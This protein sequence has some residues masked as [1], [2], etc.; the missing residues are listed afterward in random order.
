MARRWC[1]TIAVIGL[2]ARGAQAQELRGVV[3]DSATS[4]PIPA[5]VLMLLDASG[6]TLGRNI[7]NERGEFRI[8][9]SP[10]IARLRVVRIGFRPRELPVPTTASIDIL[11][12]SLPTMLEPV[13]VSAGATCPRR[14]DDARTYALLEQARAGLLSVVVARDA[15]PGALVLL[16]FERTIE[17][18][19]DRIASQRVRIDSTVRAKT[20]FSAAH[21]ATDFVQRGF[22]G[23]SANQIIF[24]APDA[25]VLLDDGFAAGYCFRI[26]N[27][28][29]DRPNEIGLAFSAADRRNGRIDIDGTLWVDTVARALRDIEFR[30]VGLGRAIEL[31]RPGGRIAFSE[32]PNGTMLVD[33]WLLRLIAT[34]TDTIRIDVRKEIRTRFH[35]AENG[36]ELARAKWRD[37]SSWRGSLG[38]VRISARTTDGRP[39][40]GAVAQL[41]DTHYR[42]VADAN[43]DIEISDLVPGPYSVTLADARLGALGLVIPT[44]LT[45]VAQRDSTVRASIVAHGARDFVIDRCVADRKYA[46]SDS[47]LLVGRAVDA[48]GQPLSGISIALAE[49]FSATE[50]KRLPDIY[51]TGSDGVFAV[52]S[53]FLRRGMTLAVYARRRGSMLWT[54]E[55][56]LDENLTV[57]RIPI[58]ARK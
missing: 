10:A 45:F 22:T 39:L 24:F 41:R 33:Q 35:A 49:V 55:V 6:T 4:Q 31:R 50:E 44:T 58:G 26:A 29:A 40:V 48:D 57:L 21:A 19:G 17:D 25:D 32:M 47:V 14:S 3:R 34:E 46:P 28:G 37:G 12:R 42:G 53:K 52:C 2:L 15:N 18:N 11:M 30:Y 7:T 16:S 23:D 9:L 43:G 13:R 27:A 38:T 56:R 20:S 8:V 51:T 1:G 5:A 36:G 54:D